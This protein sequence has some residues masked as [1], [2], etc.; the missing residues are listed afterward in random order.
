MTELSILATTLSGIMISFIYETAPFALYFLLFSSS[1]FIASGVGFVII[2]ILGKHEP[3][4]IKTIY[5]TRVV[6]SLVFFCGMLIFFLGIAYLATFD[7]RFY[8]VVI[9]PIAIVIIPLFFY[10]RKSKPS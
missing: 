4:D 5:W 6:S 1:C 8:F 7:M 3:Y 2:V 9:I 10:W